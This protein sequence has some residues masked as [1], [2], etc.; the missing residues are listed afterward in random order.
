MS[1][2]EACPDAG[3]LR[4]YALGRL[5]E[6]DHRTID[7]HLA[8]CDTCLER[9]RR[10]QSGQDATDGGDGG[11]AA[12]H[13]RAVAVKPSDGSAFGFLEPPRAEGE[14]GRLAGYVVYKLLGQ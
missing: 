8:A 14:L 6:H 9:V 13:A 5:G 4:N 10:L 2:V 12:T 11:T 3:Q 1:A 7:G